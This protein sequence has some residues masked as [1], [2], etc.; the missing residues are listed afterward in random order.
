[1]R[2][3]YSRAAL[4]VDEI[5]RRDIAHRRGWRPS[6]RERLNT[7]SLRG[8]L[9]ELDDALARVRSLR[10]DAHRCAGCRDQ[11]VE[12][13]R[14]SR[15]ELADVLGCVYQLAH[16]LDEMT[17]AELDAEAERKLR[18]RF[19]DAADIPIADSRP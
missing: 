6:A 18:L 2:Q 12:A 1:M 3:P 8:E 5:N 15:E 13:I 10:A 9:K 17:Y 11:L 16:E 19:A 7:R 14:H 4:L